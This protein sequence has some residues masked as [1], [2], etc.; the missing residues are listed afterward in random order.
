VIF[1]AIKAVAGYLQLFFINL[2]I[3][4]KYYSSF[5]APMLSINFVSEVSPKITGEIKMRQ[6]LT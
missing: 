5:I 3:R 2:K 4:G 1:A 6:L